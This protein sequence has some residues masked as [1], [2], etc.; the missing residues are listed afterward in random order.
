[1]DWKTFY[2]DVISSVAWPAIA[3]AFL[4]MFRKPMQKKLEQI[5]EATIGGNNFKFSGAEPDEEKTK[6]VEQ[7]VS[8]G[9]QAKFDELLD[10]LGGPAIRMLLALSGKRKHLPL[11]LYKFEPAKKRIVSLGL[12]TF[13]EGQFTITELGLEVV[14]L[15]V[16]RRIDRMKAIAISNNTGS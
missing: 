11:T 2:S 4:L 8:S 5:L 9:E 10:D 6:E 3:L 1:M 14:R 15:Q 12:A 7:A 16:Q 13:D